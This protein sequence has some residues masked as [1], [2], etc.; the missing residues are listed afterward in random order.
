MRLFTAITVVARNK[1]PRRKYADTASAMPNHT[2]NDLP[3]L[4]GEAERETA[5]PG[6]NAKTD[7]RLNR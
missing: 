6:T 4:A 5:K 3:S 1:P 7:T 2:G